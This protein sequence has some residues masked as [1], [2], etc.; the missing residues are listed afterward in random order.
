[1][2]ITF[3]D[4]QRVINLPSRDEVAPPEAETQP[5]ETP[6]PAAGALGGLV[7]ASP[8]AANDMAAHAEADAEAPVLAGRGAAEPEP[9]PA[10]VSVSGTASTFLPLLLGLLALAVWLGQQLWQLAA[11]RESLVAAHAAQQTPV[12]SATKLRASLDALA[13]DTQRLAD[14]GNANAGALVEELRRRG[15]TISTAAAPR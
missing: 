13:A 2:K 7:A 12:D 15:I 14:A 1:M 9:A 3:H 10:T 6:E 11:D 4:S 5:P 8:V